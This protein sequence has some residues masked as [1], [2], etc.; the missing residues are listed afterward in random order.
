MSVRRSAPYYWLS[1]SQAVGYLV[2]AIVNTVILVSNNNNASTKDDEDNDD[3][4]DDDG[5]IGIDPNLI[6]PIVFT[7]LLAVTVLSM[8]VGQPFTKQMVQHKVPVEVFVSSNSK[9]HT[10]SMILTAVW[11][12]IFGIASIAS[13]ISFAV[14]DN[15]NNNDDDDDDDDHSKTKKNQD[16]SLSELWSRWLLYLVASF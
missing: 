15:N 12:V 9:F 16:R 2:M 1:V 6:S 8:V 7:L 3:G 10:I 5:M 11:V 13:W 14:F 4:D